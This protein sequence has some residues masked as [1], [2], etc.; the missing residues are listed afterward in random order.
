MFHLERKLSHV[1]DTQANIPGLEFTSEET[2]SASTAWVY[3]KWAKLVFRSAAMV[4]LVSVSANT[5]AT[6]KDSAYL[7]YLTFG[8]DVL[9]GIILSVE[10][11]A[12]IYIQGAWTSRASQVSQT[13]GHSLRN[14]CI[15]LTN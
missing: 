13:E 10:M 4:S 8:V 6:L 3:T 9:V 1:R 5:P 2:N 12:K 15:K 11:F 14:S 7:L